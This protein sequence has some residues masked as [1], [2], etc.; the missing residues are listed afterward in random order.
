ME[1]GPPA[2]DQTPDRPEPFGYKVSWFALKTSDPAAV[3]DALELGEAMPANWSSGMA[4]A[5]GRAERYWIFISPPQGG[6]VLAISSSWVYPTI[7]THHDIGAKF[8]RLFS[9]LMKRFD[10]VQFFGSHRVSDFAAWARAMIGEPV[11]IFAWAGSDGAVFMNVGDQ[12]PEE[13][14]LGLL[15]LTGLSPDEATEAMFR[16][17]EEQDEDEEKGTKSFPE[18]DDVVGLAALWSIDPFELPEQDHPPALGLA[19]RL[20]TDLRQ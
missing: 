9:R 2:F 4:A 18:E 11:R 14:K 10:D 1:P 16:A 13:A 17:A 19:A 12:T 8:D 6:W 7:E 5:Y 20:P 3:L 15:N